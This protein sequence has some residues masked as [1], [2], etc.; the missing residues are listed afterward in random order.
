[1]SAIKKCRL[2]ELPKISDTRGNLTFVEAEHHVPFN[3]KRVYYLYD[4][5][6]GEARGGHGH[7]RLWQLMV[8]LAGSF[9]VTLTDSFEEKRFILNRP[10]QGLLIS[11][12]IWRE[13][14]DF[15]SGSVCLVCA[16]DFYSEDDYFRDYRDFV[17]AAAEAS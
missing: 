14:S 12:M 8:A 16:S 1:M 4:I 2:I 6:A 5:P 9:E 15:S 13:L 10:F 17:T 3:I 11:P 7:K